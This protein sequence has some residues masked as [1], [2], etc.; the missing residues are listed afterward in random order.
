MVVRVVGGGGAIVFVVRSVGGLAV[1]VVLGC[2]KAESVLL[3]V[4]FVGGVAIVV[5]GLARAP[6]SFCAPSDRRE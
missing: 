5:V 6:T 1:V 3:A 4:R 2:Y